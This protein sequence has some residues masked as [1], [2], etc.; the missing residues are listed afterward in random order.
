MHR[1]IRTGVL[2]AVLGLMRLA[3]AVRA[4]RGAMLLLAGAVLTA[5]GIMVP[6]AWAFIGGMLVLL[7]G[8]AVALGVSELRHHAGRGPA[9]GWVWLVSGPRRI[10]EPAR[11]VSPGG[12]RSI[13]A[14]VVRSRAE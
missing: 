1:W 6:S 13:V 10:G 14:W 2:F 11:P 3:R 4:R 5:A 7:R 9:A 8:V 12:H